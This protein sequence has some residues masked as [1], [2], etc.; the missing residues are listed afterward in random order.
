MSWSWTLQSASDCLMF[1]SCTNQSG[2][3]LWF[4]KETPVLGISKNQNQ[5]TDWFWVFQKIR[6]KEL[7]GSWYLK[8]IRIKELPVLGNF[9]T[10]KELPV[11]WKN[12]VLWLHKFLLGQF[13]GWVPWKIYL[14]GQFWG[15]GFCEM[16]TAGDIPMYPVWKLA[17]NQCCLK[18]LPNTGTKQKSIMLSLQVHAGYIH[19][20]GVAS[21]YPQLYHA[22]STGVRWIYT[23]LW[24][25]FTTSTAITQDS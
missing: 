5:R 6:I 21:Q 12:H 8:N 19:F 11:F 18:E 1:M 13:W 15:R 10:L 20:S 2:V 25:C 3:V 4:F 7:V 22:I 17:K 16:G 23:F 24:C 9:K 14:P